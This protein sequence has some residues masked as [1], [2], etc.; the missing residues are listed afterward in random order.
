MNI[1]SYL[2]LGKVKFR[3]FKAKM[4]YII[5]KILLLF[6]KILILHLIKIQE[7]ILII[8]IKMGKYVLSCLS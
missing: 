8:N 1:Y 6:I 7:K 5:I 4:I 3:K 2:Y